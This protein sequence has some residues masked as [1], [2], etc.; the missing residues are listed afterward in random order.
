M[1]IIK[2]DEKKNEIDPEMLTPWQRENLKYLK[3]HGNEPKWIQEKAEQKKEPPIEEEI[4]AVEEEEPPQ[5]PMMTE[6]ELLAD[7]KRKR[8]L[9]RRLTVLM[10]FFVLAILVTTYFISPYSKLGQVHIVGANAE[11]VSALVTDTNFK[12]NKNLLVQYFQRAKALKKMKEK[13][14]QIKTANLKIENINQFSIKV[15]NYKTIAYE[16]E[17]DV[18]H[19]ILENAVIL[20]TTVAKKEDNFLIFKNF[21]SDKS[22]KN[23]IAAI[24]NLD[25]DI[26]D[27]ITNVMA[28]PSKSNSHLIT[29][30]MKDGN[31]VIASTVDFKSK[32]IYYPKVAAQMSEKGIIDMEAGIFSYPFN[33][34]SKK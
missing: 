10:T 3:D 20:K 6:A 15:V 17:G 4:P 16:Q 30:N 25:K 32:I 18:Y 1:S 11:D 29:L 23:L 8:E 13:N 21:K 12:T 5:L 33:N 34:N 27:N 19:P 2:K 22:F 26:T 28:T 24:R 9:R 7:A 31:Q 14:P